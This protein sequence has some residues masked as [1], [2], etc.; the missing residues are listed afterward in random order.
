MLS[1]QP[2]PSGQCQCILLPPCLPPGMQRIWERGALKARS[3]RA[4]LAPMSQFKKLHRRSFHR[5]WESAACK[6][7]SAIRLSS[8]LLLA[9]ATR[10]S[11]LASASEGACPIPKKGITCISFGRGGCQEKENA[12]EGV[13]HRNQINLYQDSGTAEQERMGCSREERAMC[14]VAN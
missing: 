9:R 8:F 2:L 12:R 5:I 13:L 7:A 10:L 3:A 6:N 14:K 1:S 4:R 11:F